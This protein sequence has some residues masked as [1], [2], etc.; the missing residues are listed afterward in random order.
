[1]PPHR[2]AVG[3]RRGLFLVLE[4][5]VVGRGRGGRGPRR[6]GRR[7]APTWTRSRTCCAGGGAGARAVGGGAVADGG[8]GADRTA[9]AAG[10]HCAAAPPSCACRGG[11]IRLAGRFFGQAGPDDAVPFGQFPLRWQGADA[12]ARCAGGQ[13]ASA[14]PPLAAGGP[15]AS[16]LT[17]GPACCGSAVCPGLRVACSSPAAERGER[18]LRASWAFASGDRAPRVGSFGSTRGCTVPGAS[19][20]FCP[21]GF[22]FSSALSLGAESFAHSGL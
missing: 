5:G 13:V 9:G 6:G 3:L 8:N 16:A 21:C 10:C 20:R 7:P 15:S 1:M 4:L 12:R 2:A 17:R 19:N 22:L 11:C 18:R 14:S